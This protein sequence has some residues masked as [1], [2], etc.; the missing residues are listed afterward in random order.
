MDHPENLEQQL[1]ELVYELLPDDQAQEVCEKIGA[2]PDVA[3]RYAEVKLCSELVAEASRLQTSPVPLPIP[4]LSNDLSNDQNGTPTA[5]EPGAPQKQRPGTPDDLKEGAIVAATTAA[6][7]KPWLATALRFSASLA[8]VLLVGFVGFAYLKPQSPL[9]PAEFQV[10]RK[11]WSEQP[12]RTLLLAPSRLQSQPSN[13]LTVMTRSLADRARSTPI[14]YRLYGED[15]RVLVDAQAQT[16]AAG[17]LQIE[18]P[19]ELGDRYIRLEVQP[20][21]DGVAAPL[22]HTFRVEPSKWITHLWL[23]EPIVRPGQSLRYRTVSLT[24][25]DLQSD[26]EIEVQVQLVDAVGQVLEEMSSRAWT[27]NGVRY[28]RMTIPVDASPGAYRVVARSPQDHF[29]AVSRAVLVQAGQHLGTRDAS[30]SSET[31]S[32]P[33]DGLTIDFFP[34]SGD[35]VAGVSNRVYFHASDDQGQPVSIQGRIVDQDNRWQTDVQTELEGRGLFVVTPEPDRRYRLE[36]ESPRS[37]TTSFWLPSADPERWLV[38]DGGPGV[39]KPGSDLVLDV[40]STDCSRPLAIMATCRGAVVGQQIVT[41]DHFLKRETEPNCGYCQVRLPIAERAEGVIR[42]TAYD[43]STQPA[44]PVAQRLVYRRP[45][46]KLQVQVNALRSHYAPG[47]EVQ[48]QLKVRDESGQDQPAVLGVAVMDDLLPSPLPKHTFS[49]TQRIWLTSQVDDPRTL[50]AADLDPDARRP[51][52]SRLLDL[53]LGTQRSGRWGAS[54]DGLLAAEIHRSEPAAAME[55]RMGTVALAESVVPKIVADNSSRVRMLADRTLADLR[56]ARESDLRRMGLLALLG[57]LLVTVATL[58]LGLVRGSADPYRWAPNLAVACL[59]M[60]MG[61]FW[62]S[63]SIDS[64][65]QLSWSRRSMH[66]RADFQ[67]AEA[68]PRSTVPES[69]ATAFEAPDAEPATEAAP[70]LTEQTEQAVTAYDSISEE[71]LGMAAADEIGADDFSAPAPDAAPLAAARQPSAGM[72]MGGRGISGMGMAGPREPAAPMDMESP[73]I[74]ARSRP[75]RSAEAVD[76]PAR[77]EGRRLSDAPSASL[78]A[79]APADDRDAEDR[80]DADTA[81]DDGVRYWNPIAVADKQGQYRLSLSLPRQHATYRLRI[82][83]HHAGRIGSQQAE[84]V[85]GKATP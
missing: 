84:I 61:I 22:S 4:K 47:D 39:F 9:R 85:I 48:L 3:R 50:E 42:V 63:A 56:T 71:A 30:E 36:I 5:L 79:P 1:W 16:D 66:E 15:D 11:Q 54:T 44:R 80:T 6:L 77:L 25:F 69:P 21:G 8:A 53:L 60:I 35:L 62:V 2:D 29:D 41:S 10:E 33:P 37:T 58:M 64:Q 23:D 46:R 43:L 24:S 13:Y 55:F 7:A 57:G 67:V 49:L 76:E 45:H 81:T 70:R 82:D 17:I 74:M 59:G 27:E 40:R 75:L 20:M 68:V 38:L 28:G 52:T 18:T 83:A 12:V 31:A 78:I 32:I 14:A 73:G 72:G 34:E 51:E 19:A 65:G 26:Q